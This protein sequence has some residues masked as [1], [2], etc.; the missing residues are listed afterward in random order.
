MPSSL[1]RIPAIVFPVLLII[2]LGCAGLREKEVLSEDQMVELLR[3]FYLQ[4]ARYKEARLTEDSAILVFTRLRG[5]YAAS[6]GY[7]DSAIDRSMNYYL[8]HPEVL[9]TLYDRVID[10]LVLQ[11][12]R[13]KAKPQRRAR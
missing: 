11:E 2:A 3:D 5:G 7:S 4:E 8:D 1:L 9:N 6:K 13:L 12:Q 10:S